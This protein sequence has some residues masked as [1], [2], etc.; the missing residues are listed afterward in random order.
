MRRGN[1]YQIANGYMGYR[2][3]LDEFGPEQL[4]G[5]TLAGIF[6]RVG[7]AWREPVN[8]PN[9]G[10]TSV[11]LGGVELTALGAKVARHSQ[12]LRFANA[13]F[14]R[15]TAFASKGTTLT[16]RS[17]RFLSAETPNLGVIR[18]SVTCDR[19]ATVTIRTGIDGNIWD[20]NG[21]HLLRISATRRDSVLAVEGLTNEA[22]KR[23]VVA[24][25]ADIGFGEA[26]YESGGNRNLRVV[27]LRAEAGKTYTFHKYFAVF[28][29]NDAVRGP[30]V[31]AAVEAVQ[32]ARARGYD[33]CLASHSAR[34]KERWE[35]C[36]VTID[37]DDEAQL[38]LRYS[39]LQLL[40]VAPVKGSSNSIPARALTG[41]V[42][43][44]AIFW[45]TEMFMFPFFLH[46]DPQ[47]A[48]ELMRYRIKTLDGARR[49][50]KTEGLGYRGAF[51]AWE[52]QDTGDD[53]CTYFNIGDPSTGRELRTYFRDKQVHISGDVAIAMWDYFRLTGDDS[54]LLEGGAEVI[55]E[56]A[57]FYCSLAY[58]KQDKRRYEILDVTGPDEYHERVGN[59]AFTSM[60]AKETLNIANE[61]VKH[62]RRKHPKALSLLFRKLR[63]EKELPGFGEV[64]R[65]LFVPRPDAKTGI[66]EQFDGYLGLRESTVEDL[67]AQM[68]HPNEYLGAGQG[69]AVPTKII[70]QADVVMM[71]NLFRTRFST[72]IKKA[73]W[74]YYEPRTEHG[75]SLSACAYAMVAT[76]FGNLDFA[77][78]YFLKTAKIDLEARYKVYV[79][80]V[81][82]GGSHPAANGGAWMTAILGFGG[83][84]ADE[85]RIAINPRLCGKWKR[86]QFRL[87]YKGDDFR[88]SITKTSVT[89]APSRAN[90]RTHTVLVAGRSVKCGPG[91]PVTI[92][93]PLAR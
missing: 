84:E 58:Y 93:Y 12:T 73:N 69:L 64:A 37:G 41:Q 66:I 56:C 18:F 13:L 87:A 63:I 30:V 50:A 90:G 34:W 49:K 67:K 9:G 77:Y 51:Y 23:V 32:H 76:E 15:E 83:V 38:A 31:E 20:L 26:T 80:S 82:M 17:S 59:N 65:R 86:L 81:F 7:S 16:V 19:A 47:K 70:K 21:P 85:N 89:V 72:E 43:K 78:K 46:T 3:T 45:D 35:R 5:I 10:Y 55:L 27:H 6:D 24:E 42:Y 48:V 25:A 57:R 40:M 62:L 39:I 54:L 29:D 44:G 8:A 74:D 61:T 88:I 36:D 91:R 92:K 14:Q 28:T 1:I 60:V 2:G 11:S 52:S 68:V 79:G 4:V 75:S 53:A 22:S 33:A 71:L